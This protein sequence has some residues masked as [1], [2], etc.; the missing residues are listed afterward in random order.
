M[1][2]L[3]VFAVENREGLQADFSS[4][5]FF[6]ASSKNLSGATLH[7]R[8][9]GCSELEKSV[10]TKS[11]IAVHVMT[12]RRNVAFNTMFSI[13]LPMSCQL[14]KVVPIRK[15]DSREQRRLPFSPS[16]GSSKAAFLCMLFGLL[17]FVGCGRRTNSF[18]E[19][20]LHI[21]RMERESGGS[22]EGVREEIQA[23]LQDWFGTPD[24]PRWPEQ[25]SEL[26]NLEIEKLKLASGPVGRREDGIERGLYRKH[27]AVC[28]GLAGDGVGPTA[29]LLSPYPRDFRRGTFKFKSTPIGVKPTRE[30]LKRTLLEGIPGTS[31]PSFASLARTKHFEDDIDVL[32]EYVVYLSIRGEVERRLIT[33]AALEWDFVEGRFYDPLLKEGTEAYT[34]QQDRLTKELR[35]VA[36]SWSQAE[37][38]VQ[39]APESNLEFSENSKTWNLDMKSVERGREL[40]RSQLT[41]CSSCHGPEGLG[42]GTSKDFDEWTKDWTIRA[43]IDPD[44]P[45]EWKP[46]RKLGALKPVRNSPRNLQL[47]AFRGGSKPEDIFHRIAYGIDGSSM[48]AVLRASTYPDGLNDDQIWDLVQFI[49]S[50]SQIESRI[51]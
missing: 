12:F 14:R 13:Y 25:A 17:L 5:L 36:Q 49:L 22:L 39:V 26:W 1:R 24:D 4:T 35:W 11:V 45:E 20:E 40:F 2:K 3:C 27:C 37:K 9:F 46:L 23:C 32:V 33:A 34:R 18:L 19:N 48:P 10:K 6:L 16:I 50:L 28:H 31:M 38:S 43:G 29:G 47:G 42:N 7:Q 21:V 51:Q 44:R 15:A 30:D 41:G 8:E